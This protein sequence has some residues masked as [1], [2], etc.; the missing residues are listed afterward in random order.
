MPYNF[1][2][3]SICIISEQNHLQVSD[4]LTISFMYSKQK[5]DQV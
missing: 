2:A 4:I 3:D 5:V 1:V